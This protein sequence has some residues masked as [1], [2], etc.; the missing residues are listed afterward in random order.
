MM[1]V[2]EL[3]RAARRARRRSGTEW[4]LHCTTRPATT[5]TSG[6]AP[7]CGPCQRED[8][9]EA[10]RREEER[11]EAEPEERWLWELRIEE[12]TLTAPCPECCRAPSEPVK[13]SCFIC[14]DA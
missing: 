14:G 1:S 4:C 11:R 10:A 7:T 3:E 5:T 6:G 13:P 2:K 8:E 9:R 12:A